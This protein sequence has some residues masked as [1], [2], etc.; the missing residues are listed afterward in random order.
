MQTHCTFLLDQ[1][2]RSHE[3]F[4]CNVFPIDVLSV[5]RELSLKNRRARR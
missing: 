1:C 5:V 4:S 3:N 2:E